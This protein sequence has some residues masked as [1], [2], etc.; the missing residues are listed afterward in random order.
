[1]SKT[2]LFGQSFET[3]NRDIP[4]Q[5]SS[6]AYYVDFLPVDFKP[7]EKDIICGRAR[8]NFHHDGNRYFR[9]LIQQNVGPY[10]AA[11]TKVE[12]TEAIAA[13]V[14]KIC[15]N[16]PSG[17]FIK[18]DTNT[19]RWYRIKESEARDKVGHAIRK[20]VQRLEETKPRLAAR[21]RKEYTSSFPLNDNEEGDQNRSQSHESLIA[22]EKAMSPILS[23][24]KLEDDRKISGI[25]SNES[26][27]RKQLGSEEDTQR[28]ISTV[29]R[30]DEASLAAGLSRVCT[31][32]V[33]S[34]V[35]EQ[36]LGQNIAGFGVTSQ[37]GSLPSSRSSL[38]GLSVMSGYFTANNV[39]L[40]PPPNSMTTVDSARLVA[41]SLLATPGIFHRSATLAHAYNQNVGMS[42][43]TTSTGKLWLTAAALRHQQEAQKMKELEYA[44]RLAFTA[45]QDMSHTNI[46]LSVEAL[47]QKKQSSK[48]ETKNKGSDK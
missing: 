23:S 31:Q 40:F 6:S 17:G 41:A 45:L 32:D 30:Q 24:Q 34:S 13:I 7:S 47:T 12:K 28:S 18:K 29:G 43:Q 36:L 21:I 46:S 33:Q 15:Q 48:D 38:G 2:P 42:P 37:Q 26:P 5:A 39:S 1:M 3:T 25:S 10:L 19:G 4:L 9:D 16:S 35:L 8:E 20:A 11:R 44:R 14:N 22:S 27:P